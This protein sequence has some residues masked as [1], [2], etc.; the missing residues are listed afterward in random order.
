MPEI[1]IRPAIA[2]DIPLLSA[3]DNLYTSE[4]VWKME[5]QF[6]GKEGSAS[7]PIRTV[8]FRQ[9]RLPR[10]VRVAHPRSPKALAADWTDRSGL[11]V[12]SLG[13]KPIGYVSLDLNMG[14]NTTWVTELVVDRQLRRQGIGSALMLAALEWG[15]NMGSQNLVLE[16]QP[17]NYPAIRLAQK[18]GFELCGYNDR[19][20]A[21]QEIGIFFGRTL[22]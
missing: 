16:M 9:M 11:L 2:A 15:M 5:L 18:L 12:A 14:A 1:E 6:E 4:N 8:N 13:G 10:A 17:K 19:F 7:G 21:N 22:R 3:L 20:Y